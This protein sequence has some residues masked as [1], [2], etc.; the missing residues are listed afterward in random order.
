M[1][2]TTVTTTTVELEDGT[3]TTLETTWHSEAGSNP[4]LAPAGMAHHLATT[5]DQHLSMWS[6]MGQRPFSG[7]TGMVPGYP[8]A[9][10]VSNDR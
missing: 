1:K 5:K 4:R 9:K 3:K 8:D 2:F 10:E 7:N 6:G